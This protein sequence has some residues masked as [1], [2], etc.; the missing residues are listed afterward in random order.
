MAMPQIPARFG[1]RHCFE[2]CTTGCRKTPERWTTG[3]APAGR[4]RGDLAAVGLAPSVVPVLGWRSPPESRTSRASVAAPRTKPP[5]SARARPP[6]AGAPPLPRARRGPSL[7]GTGPG[8]SPAQRSLRPNLAASRLQAPPRAAHSWR[9]A[10]GP[11]AGRPRG[12]PNAAPGLG[13][14]PYW[15]LLFHQGVLLTAPGSLSASDTSPHAAGA[16]AA[17]PPQSPRVA[18]ESAPHSD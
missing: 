16:V 9:L 1:H 11:E 4:P 6:E 12:A 10:R 7:L 15:Q 14:S 5:W 3:G 18:A 2:G 17:W 8:I 13:R